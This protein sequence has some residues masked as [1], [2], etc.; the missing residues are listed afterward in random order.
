MTGTNQQKFIDRSAAQD[1]AKGIGI[2]AVVY[3]HVWRGL[4]NA[5]I[6]SADSLW[7]VVDYSFY[8]WHMP[9]FLLLAGY[10]V[11]GSLSRSSARISAWRRTKLLVPMYFFWAILQ[12]GLKVVMSK[13][14][15]NPIGIEALLT[16]FYIPVA[17]FWFLYALLIFHLVAA[18]LKDRYGLA[19]IIAIGL[20]LA[21][22][23]AVE[24]YPEA[25]NIDSAEYAS[26]ADFGVFYFLGAYAAS[27]SWPQAIVTH[28]RCVIAGALS[29]MLF[30]A[31][32]TLGISE[33]VP[34][35]SI[36]VLP[37][38]FAAMFLVFLAS[39]WLSKFPIGRALAALGKVSLIVF[40][41]HIIFL[42]AWRVMLLK[43]GIVSPGI[44]LLS[45]MVAGIGIPVL[46]YKGLTR[47]NLQRLVFLP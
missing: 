2:T 36:I 35:F 47:Y 26:L 3:S 15:N 39:Q 27:K 12:V 42:A 31:F 9:L 10:N 45:G 23:L 16:P 34:Y 28:R 43:V 40:V 32:L 17:Q 11:H 33:H 44:H 25:A 14:V 8:L 24:P 20:Y 13:Q 18:A 22:H 29:P 46:I 6:S 4:V 1:I 5:G 41:M 37:A 7:E 30:A 38:T 19:F 21:R